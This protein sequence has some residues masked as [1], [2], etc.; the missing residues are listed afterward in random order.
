[1]KSDKPIQKRS[2]RIPS[3]FGGGLGVGERVWQVSLIVN[4]S[5]LT[6]A[7]RRLG[8]FFCF[9]K[10][11]YPKKRRPQSTIPSGFP[12]CAR[13]VRR[14]R[15]SHCVL[16]QSSPTTP[17]QPPLLGGGTGE[18]QLKNKSKSKPTSEANFICMHY[19][20]TAFLLLTCL[21]L[22]TALIFYKQAVQLGED[23]LSTWLRS[24]SCEFR[25]PACL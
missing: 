5:G 7:A 1:M 14:L 17:D 13:L 19:V 10:R 12:A 15:N 3:P 23:C 4:I 8:T 20:P 24:R 16:R 18:E 11:K 9:A 2:S 22:R 21:P 6:G 25:S